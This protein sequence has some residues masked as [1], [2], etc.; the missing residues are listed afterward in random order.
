MIEAYCCVF[1][2]QILAPTSQTLPATSNIKIIS[3]ILKKFNTIIQQKQLTS[4]NIIISQILKNLTPSFNKSN[5]KPLQT[6]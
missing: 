3:H 1:K 6:L 5:S 2:D 4:N